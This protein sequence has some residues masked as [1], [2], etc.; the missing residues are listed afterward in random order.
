[1]NSADLMSLDVDVVIIGAGPVGL[2]L[3]IDLGLRGISTVIVERNSG[4]MRL[5]KMERT[6]PR[7]MEI[8]RRLGVA[9]QIR[10]RGLQADKAMDIFLVASLARPPLTSIRYPTVNE[11]RALCEM[12][13]DGTQ[14]REP[15]QLISQYTLEPILIEKAQSLPAVK[16]LFDTELETLAQ[17][18]AGV[19]AQVCTLNEKRFDIQAK[20]L[21]GADGAN[22]RVRSLVGIEMEGRSNLGTITNIFFRCDDL[23]VKHGVPQGRHWHFVNESANGGSGGSIVMQD[24]MRHFGYHTAA[25]PDGDPV[26]FLRRQTGLDIRPQVLRVGRWTQNMLVARKHRE[27]RVFLAGDSNH[28]YIPAGGLGMNTGVVDAINLGWKLQ[29]VLGGWGGIGLLESYD[30]ERNASARR[31]LGFVAY[32]VEGSIHMRDGFQPRMLEDTAASRGALNAY[33]TQAVPLMRRVYDMHGADRGY[34]YA[35]S[36]VMEEAG[37]PPPDDAYRYHP[38]TYPGSHLP[39]VWLAA[40]VSIYD[41]LGVGYGLLKLG[42]SPPDTAGL[43][44]AFRQHGAPLSVLTI[45]DPGIARIYA[46]P[47]I[48]VRPDLHVSWRG[49]A[50]PKDAAI[51]AAKVLGH[52]TATLA[53]GPQ[54]AG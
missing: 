53:D 50:E 16:I 15:W 44:A 48:L 49:A 37:A 22:S 6:N 32:A 30:A 5:P 4:P 39:H 17:D 14:P 8:Y 36:I 40:G 26:E 11:A 28:N 27:S 41:K 34:R 43:E 12:A 46:E 1:M 21:V 42:A 24:D 20:Y 51:L 25:A 19:R 45:A 35:S 23:L 54:Q 2:T 38:S 52:A 13:T 29:A 18:A 10:A 33:L 7:S 31:T 3:A 9:E 47:L